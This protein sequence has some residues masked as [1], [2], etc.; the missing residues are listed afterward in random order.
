MFSV[1]SNSTWRS[2][3]FLVILHAHHTN[4]WARCHKINSGIYRNINRCRKYLGWQESVRN[5]SSHKFKF[6][7]FPW[8]YVCSPYP[9]NIYTNTNVSPPKWIHLSTDI[10]HQ[11]TEV[12]FIIWQLFFYNAFVLR[13]HDNGCQPLQF[14]HF[15]MLFLLLFMLKGS[16]WIVL[17]QQTQ[18]ICLVHN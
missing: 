17:S 10:F 3:L 9:A 6:P 7:I 11:S 12:Y 16:V 8:H 14:L 5:F 15:N 13:N 1:C 18:N 2:L 4:T